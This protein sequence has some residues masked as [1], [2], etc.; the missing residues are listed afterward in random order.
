MTR[1][2]TI[3]GLARRNAITVFVETGGDMRHFPTAAHLCSWG[4][5][6]PGQ[7]ESARQAADGQDAG[8]Q[9]LPARRADRSGPRH[10][11]RAAARRCRRATTGS[12]GIAATRKPSS[13]SGTRS[14]KSRT[15]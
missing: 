13:P 4:A 14:S 8:R 11:T 15:T 12:N 6:C 7:Q 5:M 1:L 3:P 2:M 9:P 10:D